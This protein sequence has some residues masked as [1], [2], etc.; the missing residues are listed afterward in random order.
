MN[1][2]STAP[3]LLLWGWLGA[4]PRELGGQRIRLRKSAT[5]EH[6]RRTIIPS[7]WGLIAECL[8]GSISSRI[9]LDFD[10]CRKFL[11]PQH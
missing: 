9:K 1:A 5:L 4:L 3:S 7:S 2:Q 8:L 10:P 11:L 6:E